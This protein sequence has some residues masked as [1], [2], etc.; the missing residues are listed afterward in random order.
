MSPHHV[1]WMKIKRAL[2]EGCMHNYAVCLCHRLMMPVHSTVYSVNACVIYYFFIYAPQRIKHSAVFSHR[3]VR[4]QSH[5][6]SPHPCPRSALARNFTA[7]WPE[8]NDK[9]PHPSYQRC[10]RSDVYVC[11]VYLFIFFF[12]VRVFQQLFWVCKLAQHRNRSAWP[13]R[14]DGWISS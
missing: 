12:L 3:C 10:L 6:C 1:I 14:R 2:D 8:T 7:E 4:W 13:P 5:S 9:A 11:S